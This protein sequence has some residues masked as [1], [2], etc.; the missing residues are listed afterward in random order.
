MSGTV[1]PDPAGRTAFVTGAGSGLG[2]AIA[3][4]LARAGARVALVGR[5]PEPLERVAARIA[6]DDGEALAIPCDITQDAQV[7]SA[8]KMAAAALGPVEIL[9]NN[10]GAAASSP[11]ER[12]SDREI[13]GLLALNVR[14]PYVLAKA[15]IPGMKER[16]WGRIVNIASTAALRGFRYCSLYTASKHALAGL[17][18]TLAAELLASGITVNAVCPGYA[19]TE[20]V[21]AASRNIA[22]KTGKPEAEARDFL[23]R[24]NPLQRLVAPEEVAQAVLY[25]VGPASGAVNGQSLVLDGGTQ[26]V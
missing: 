6:R 26:P 14:A 5:T 7:R 13:D 1:H 15:V 21:A 2:R 3:E 24:Q 16:R 17:T 9:V 11:L 8:V 18:R 12:H 10:A 25:L 4:A 22:A 20:M 19:D 23:A